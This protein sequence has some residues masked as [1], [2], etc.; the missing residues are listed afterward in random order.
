MVK[1]SEDCE[2][3]C[4]WFEAEVQIRDGQPV[5]FKEWAEKIVQCKYNIYM[6]DGTATSAKFFMD[7]NQI[8]D[9]NEFTRYLINRYEEATE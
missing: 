2:D 6:P 9:N 1:V 3:Q 4:P 8:F 5:G 7:M